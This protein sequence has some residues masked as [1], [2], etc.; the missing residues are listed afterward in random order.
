MHVEIARR[1]D[2]IT[3][4]CRSQHVLRLEIFGFAAPGNDFDPARGDADF[5]VEFDRSRDAV[6]V[7]LAEAPCRTISRGLEAKCELRGHSPC[8]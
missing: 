7:L 6:P 3:E 1:M 8:H 5:L 4:L 2:E